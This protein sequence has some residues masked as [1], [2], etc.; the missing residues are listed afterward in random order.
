MARLENLRNVRY[1]ELLFLSQKGDRFIADVWNTMGFND[2]PDDAFDALDATDEAQAYGA[3]FCFK[4]GPRYWTFDAL[5]ATMRETAPVKKFGELE[6]FQ[7]A[8]LDLGTDG[9]AAGPYHPRAVARDNVFEFVAGRPRW[10]ITNPA[11]ERFVMQAYALFVDRSQTIESLATLGDRL[12]MPEGWRFD[13]EAAPSTTLRVET[14]D[15]NTAWVMQDEFGNSYQ[16]MSHIVEMS[17]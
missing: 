7:A 2:C 15:E 16:M 9:P 14:G 13:Y 10:Y 3:L 6:M 17:A 11:G 8:T 5:E 4:N 1:G 12:A